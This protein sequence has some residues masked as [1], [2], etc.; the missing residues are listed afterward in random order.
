MSS[1]FLLA[2]AP[3]AKPLV[4]LPSLLLTTGARLGDIAS[5]AGL[6]AADPSQRRWP[7]SAVACRA[8]LRVDRRHRICQDT[9]RPSARPPTIQD[10]W[11]ARLYLIKAV[12]IVTL[13]MFWVVSGLIALTASRFAAASD[14]PLLSRFSATARCARHGRP[15][16]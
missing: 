6:V 10:K 12:I 3:W 16:A 5:L 7:S 2:Y 9:C 8:I 4:M 14:D 11:F 15:A 1:L 13:V